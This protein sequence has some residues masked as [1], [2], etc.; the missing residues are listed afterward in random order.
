M[1]L[2]LGFNPAFAETSKQVQP[3]LKSIKQTPYE[4]EFLVKGLESVHQIKFE[5]GAIG[6]YEFFLNRIVLSDSI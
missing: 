3:F 1:S 5:K 2:F 6:R 4:F